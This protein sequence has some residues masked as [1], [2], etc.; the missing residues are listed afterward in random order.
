MADDI[1]NV[2]CKCIF[3]QYQCSHQNSE[4]QPIAFFSQVHWEHGEIFPSY[5]AESEL[6]CCSALKCDEGP[7][8]CFMRF[9][10]FLDWINKHLC[11]SWRICYRCFAAFVLPTSNHSGNFWTSLP[12]SNSHSFECIRT[13][14]LCRQIFSLELYM[15]KKQTQTLKHKRST[16]RTQQKEQTSLVPTE[17]GSLYY[18]FRE[19]WH[20]DL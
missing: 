3:F 2:A 8:G 14:L 4:W 18:L 17:Q 5:R 16:Q 15:E 20:T 12:K 13:I 19:T 10:L 11:F 6:G 7:L 9:C 1:Q